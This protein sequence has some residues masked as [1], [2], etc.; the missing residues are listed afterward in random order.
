MNPAMGELVKRAVKY[1]V[2]GIMVAIVAFVIPPEKRA[3]KYEEIATIALMAA[4][5]FSILDTFTP[6]IGA[7]ARSG[8]G[9]GIGANMVGF[10]VL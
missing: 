1:L 3:L 8:A 7:S 4:A 10:P 6:S 5:T 2:E 9:M